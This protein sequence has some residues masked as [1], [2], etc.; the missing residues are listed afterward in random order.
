V[1]KENAMV[2]PEVVSQW[3]S[4]ATIGAD[5]EPEAPT[6]ECLDFLSGLAGS[7]RALDLGPGTGRVAIPLARRGVPVT[8][9]DISTRVLESLRPKVEGLPIDLVQGDMAEF[10]LP[11]T[12]DVVY[13]TWSTFFALLTQDDQ[14]NCFRRVSDALTP[15]GSF[16]VD[17]FSPINDAGVL[18]A[19]NVSVRATADTYVDVTYTRHRSVS[20]RIRFQEVRVCPDGNRLMPVDIRYA[21]PSE[22]D[23][24]ARLAGLRLTA[25]YSDWGKQPFTSTSYRNVAVYSAG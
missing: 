1:R 19:T 20:Q 4:Y 3:D 8:A 5:V 2:T 7:G 6:S 10:K 18:S 24:M 22:I 9:L 16:V 21:W 15:T 12:F 25:R 17:V 11:D 23:L 14:V 13:A